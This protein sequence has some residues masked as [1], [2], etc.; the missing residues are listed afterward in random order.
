MKCPDHEENKRLEDSNDSYKQT[1]TISF[2]KYLLVLT[3]REENWANL[4]I[5]FLFLAYI[6]S[7]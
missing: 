4:S 5:A 7:E 1:L 6:R 3:K 2:I